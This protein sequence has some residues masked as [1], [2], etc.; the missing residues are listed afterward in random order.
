[1]AKEYTEQLELFEDKSSKE[2]P[3]TCL[4]MTFESDEDRRAYFTEELRKKLPELRQIEG[5]PIGEDEDILALSDPPYY[6]ACPNPFIKDFIQ[7]WQEE[8]KK[9]NIDLQETYHKEPFSSDISEGKNDPIYN[10]H[11]Y[12]T[13]VPYKAVMRYILH[14]TKPGDIIFDGFCGSGM[15]GVAAEMC[16]VKSE[17]ESLGYIINNDDNILLNNDDSNDFYSKLGQRKAILSDISTAATFISY[18][19]N[20]DVN[21]DDFKNKGLKFLETLKSDL[22]WMYYTLKEGKNDFIKKI[23]NEVKSIEDIKRLKELLTNYKDHFG[24]INYVVWSDVFI[25]SSCNDEVIYWDMTV[26]KNTKKVKEELICPHCNAKLQKRDLE[27]AL[28]AYFDEELGQTIKQAKQVPVLINYRIGSKRY[29]KIPD[30]IDLKMIELF[31]SQNEKMWFPTNRMMEGGETRRNDS[32]GI[33]HV[34]HFYTKRNLYSISYALGVAEEYNDRNLYFLHGSVL[35]KLNKMN[36]F[37]PQHGS[38]ALVGPMANTLYLPP[39]FVENNVVDQFEFQYKKIAKAFTPI[40]GNIITTQSSSSFKI[41]DNSIDYIFID[42]P[43]GANIMYSELNFIREAWLKVFTNNT[44][45]AIQNKSIGKSIADYKALLSNCLKEAYRILKPLRWITVEFSNTQAGIWNIIQSALQEAGFV[46]A[47]VDVLDKQRGGLHAMTGT[48][49]VKQ[50][51]VISAYKPD[52]ELQKKFLD[53]SRLEQNIWEFIRNHLAQLPSFIGK[54]GHVEFIMER[55]PRIIYDRLVAFCIKNG[56]SVPISSIEFQSGLAQRFPMRDGMVFLESQVVEYDKKRILAKEFV[57]MNLFV[58]DENSAIEW[59]RQ[60]LLKK[61]QTRQDL[62]P[63]FMKEI[64]HIAKYE[65]LPELDMLLEQNFLRYE[66]IGPVPSQ[67]HAY[68]ST[69][70]KDLRELSKEDPKLQQKAKDRWYVPDPNKQADL[71]K[72]REKSLLREFNSYVEEIERS[73]KKLKQFRL[74]A[75]RAGFKKAWGEKDYKTI[76]EVG[77][78]I[79]ENVLQEDDKLLMYYD[80]AQIRLGI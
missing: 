68:L 30:E 80:N 23:V 18:N 72:L 45:E 39:L 58:S 19:Y 55:D 33:T 27:K 48:T 69:N 43:F 16:G 14:Y 32:S 40:G 13:K 44:Q 54:A 22:E 75:I 5:F 57:Q 42:P 28:S 12:H 46:I 76:V 60:Q 71:E 29:E 73:K 10:A 17:V 8:K 38:R 52:E 41:E 77:A 20:I 63:S 9:I 25:C 49:A 51:L 61:P 26:D 1:M 67:I 6:T 56:I 21:I 53:V 79:P 70:F 66:G 7:Q 47:S 78:K 31:N 3:V 34:H 50:D 11:S 2:G 62:H 64:Q 15:T 24:I 65:K 4:G 74:E 35:P 36:R 59:L 37:M